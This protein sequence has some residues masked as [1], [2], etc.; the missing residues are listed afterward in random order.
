MCKISMVLWY[1]VVMYMQD[2][3][4]VPQEQDSIPFQT[5]TFYKAFWSKCYMQTL[6]TGCF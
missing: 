1:C 4:F 2:G 3:V 6:Q 5:I